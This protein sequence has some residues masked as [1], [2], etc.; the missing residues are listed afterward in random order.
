MITI[1]AR[2]VPCSLQDN[3]PAFW[4][5]TNPGCVPAWERAVNIDMIMNM[6]IMLW[7]AANGVDSGY[8]EAVERCGCRIE[9]L[10]Y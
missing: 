5:W 2:L 6:E 4:S 7:A 1:D 8:V 9:G 10:C 3:I